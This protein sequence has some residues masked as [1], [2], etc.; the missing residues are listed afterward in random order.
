MG[1]SS[2]TWGPDWAQ[3]TA[4]M[5]LESVLF[6]CHSWSKPLPGSS[7]GFSIFQ[8]AGLELSLQ[9]FSSQPCLAFS[10]GRG[11]LFLFT[12][13]GRGLVDLVSFR[14]FLKQFFSLKNFPAGWN[15]LMTDC[16]E[17]G[18]NCYPTSRYHAVRTWNS[19]TYWSFVARIIWT[20]K[21]QRPR[22][23]NVSTWVT[24]AESISHAL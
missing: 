7:A 17:L 13:A 10:S 20:E 3:G 23:Q 15:V 19:Q 9:F 24:W 14:E 8:A 21:T 18:G 6:G 22:G 5:D 1:D 4:C 11:F 12:L 16:F 2:H